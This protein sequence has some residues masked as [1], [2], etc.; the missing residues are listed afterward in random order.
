[1]Q[2][3]EVLG[4]LVVWGEAQPSVLAM[5]LTSTRARPDGAVDVLSDFDL[6]LV[7]ADP[8]RFAEDR[9]W[10]SDYGEPMVRWGD[11][12]E[13]YGL[14]TYFRG[15]V[16]KDGTKIDYT[17]WP[18]ALLERISEEPVLPDMLDVGY[19]VLLDK[20][21]RASRW[22]P[23][24]YRAHIPA[25]PTE[26][27]YRDLVEEFWWS[28]TYAAKSLWRD[29]LVFNRFILEQDIRAGTLRTMLD[30]RIEI[31]HDWSL[32]PG[33]FG[34]GLKQLLPAQTWS[35]LE[36]TYVGPDSEE[37]WDALFRLAVLFGRVAREV[38]ELLGYDYPQTVDDQVT[39]YLKGVR[40]LPQA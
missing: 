38:G 6:I 23:P 12:S 11:Q 33:W 10:E 26:T 39:A 25:K 13:V 16:Y 17:I 31:D 9:A 40:K 30:W 19:R 8:E 21:G 22:E 20:D 36:S 28:M 5:I 24:T 18:D 3:A 14:T 15:L 34:R 32:K 27:E 1:M 7:V 37:S 35:E 2:E 29:E 4:R